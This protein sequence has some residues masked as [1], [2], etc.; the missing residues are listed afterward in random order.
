MDF[1]EGDPV[2]HWTY[3]LGK[4]I[5]LEERSLSGKTILYYA[6]Q[7]GELTVWVPADGMLEKRL[8]PPTSELRLKELL[9]I[10]TGPSEAL[11]EDRHERKLLLMKMI[12]DGQAESLCR[13]IRDLTAMQQVRS[14]NDSDHALLKQSQSA[15]VGEWGLVLSVTNLQ[16]EN[17]L[18]RLLALRSVES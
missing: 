15:F 18:Q 7:I 1:R 5:R 17:E 13:V 8:R 4:I 10:L 16:A 6:V 14:L 3:G 9:E 2:M 12:R 11:P